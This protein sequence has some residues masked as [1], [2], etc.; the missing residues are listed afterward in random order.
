MR[1]NQ[2]DDPNP[3][4]YANP[5]LNPQPEDE[6]RYYVQNQ[7]P[8][9]NWFDVAGSND[10]SVCKNILAYETSKGRLARIVER[11]EVVIKR[12]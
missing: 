8:S 5:I 12:N 11:V 1:I 4:D 6:V 3:W 9:G 10:L 7:S 2:F